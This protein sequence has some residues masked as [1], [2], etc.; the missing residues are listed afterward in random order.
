MVAF[1]VEAVEQVRGLRSPVARLTRGAGRVPDSVQ[2]RDLLVAGGEVFEGVH[3]VAGGV[4]GCGLDGLDLL[5]GVHQLRGEV[6]LAAE[7]LPQSCPCRGIF[8]IRSCR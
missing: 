3:G 8:L 4:R 5:S 2:Q 7:S 1:D 6:H